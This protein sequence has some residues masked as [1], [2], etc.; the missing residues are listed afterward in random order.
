MIRRFAITV[1][2]DGTDFFGWQRQARERTVQ[3][4][5]GNGLVDLNR[6]N[7]VVVNGSG[8]TDSGVHAIGQVAHFDLETILAPETI[9]NALNAKTPR[10]IY[11]HNCRETDPS[12]HARFNAKKRTYLYQ[13]LLVRSVIKR[14]YTWQPELKFREDLLQRCAE[15]VKGEHDFSRLCRTSTESNT[16]ICRIYESQWIKNENMLYYK[17]VGNRFL[18]SM[19]RMIVGTMEEVARGIGT[20]EGFRALVENLP[21]DIKPFTAP[22]QGLFLWEVEY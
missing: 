5:L 10:D 17:I 1:E 8:R 16:K 9:R 2:Y 18:H 4:V 11:I 22:P 7:R 21:G 12:F 19:V 20:V 6:G 13:L 15:L 3:E 14:R